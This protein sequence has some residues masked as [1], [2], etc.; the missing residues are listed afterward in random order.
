MTNYFFL[1]NTVYIMYK[2]VDEIA[3]Y[4]FVSVALG[5]LGL[6]CTS[7]STYSQG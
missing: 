3:L 7:N 2:Y 6:F 1:V 4:E 5:N